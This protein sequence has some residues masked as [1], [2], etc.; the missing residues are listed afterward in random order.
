ME[1]I[2][3]QTGYIS[4]NCDTEYISLNCDTGYVSLDCDMGYV[5]PAGKLL[6][7]PA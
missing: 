5:S 7:R 4:L 6:L 1:L 3:N 2:L